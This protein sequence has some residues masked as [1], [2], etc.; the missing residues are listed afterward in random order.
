MTEL[1]K[2]MKVKDVLY[3]MCGY[4]EGCPECSFF[5]PNDDADGESFC[6]IRDS[7]NLIPF[8]DDWDM[9]SAMIGD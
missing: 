7:K 5:D 1:E 9:G 3:H 2:Q 4:G 8:D 6:A